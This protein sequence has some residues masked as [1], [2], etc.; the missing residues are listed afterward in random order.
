MTRLRWLVIW[1]LWRRKQPVFLFKLH[2]VIFE[3]RLRNLRMLFITVT[4]F[5]DRPV[6]KK[7]LTPTPAYSRMH[8]SGAIQN[9]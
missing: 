4:F 7:H 6:K 2:I 3:K 1:R 5:K 8:K 9:V